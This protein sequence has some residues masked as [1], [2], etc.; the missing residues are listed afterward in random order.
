V[1]VQSEGTNDP[2]VDGLQIYNNTFVAKATGG[3]YTGLDFTSQGGGNVK[4]VSIHHNIFQGFGSSIVGQ[5]AATQSNISIATNNYFQGNAPTWSGNGVTISGNLNLNPNFNASWNT[6]NATLIA[7]GIGWNGVVTPPTPCSS[8]TYSAWST[9]INGTQTRT[10]TSSLP[11]GCSGG[12][13]P[14]LTQS[15]VVIPVLCTSYIYSAW[16]TCVNNVQTRTVTGYLPSGCS[17]TISTPP[18]L[19]QACISPIPGDTILTSVILRLQTGTSNALPLRNL[20]YIVKRANGKYYTNT[21]AEVDVI[22]YKNDLTG[23]WAIPQ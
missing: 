20:T 9:C 18:V 23:R 3:S 22:M 4:N 15:C 6:T 7:A 17:G 12:V 2:Y 11:A 21:G 14:I 5:A 1:I 13:A 19:T 16:S 10:V 8:Y